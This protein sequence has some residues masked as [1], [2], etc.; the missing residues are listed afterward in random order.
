MKIEVLYLKGCPNHQLAVGEV[1]HVLRAHGVEA[2]VDELEVTD[3]TMAQELSFLGSPSIRVDGLDVEPES[4]GAQGFGFGCRTYSDSEG[5]RSGLPSIGL[6]QQAF[7]EASVSEAAAG[8]KR[9]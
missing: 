6:I 1:L 7:I 8:I 5:R 9:V 3:S 4:R 2:P